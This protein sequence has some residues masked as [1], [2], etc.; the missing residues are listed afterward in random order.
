V[1]IQQQLAVVDTAESRCLL[2]ASNHEALAP[3]A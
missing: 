1:Q 3:L 2:E